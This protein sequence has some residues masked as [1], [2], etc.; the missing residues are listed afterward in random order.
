MKQ[1]IKKLIGLSQKDEEI[2]KLKNK[3][4]NLENTVKKFREEAKEYKSKI[5]TTVK[6][7]QNIKPSNTWK[8]H[9]GELLDRL[10]K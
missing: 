2:D 3:I 7:M 8:R 4:K 5:N 1:F 9:Y 6:Y 10:R